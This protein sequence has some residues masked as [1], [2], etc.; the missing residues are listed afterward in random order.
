ML[1]PHCNRTINVKRSHYHGI[2][3]TGNTCSST[4]RTDPPNGWQLETAR[5]LLFQALNLLNAKRFFSKLF[6][7]LSFCFLFLVLTCRF[8]KNRAWPKSFLQI[9][10]F[11]MRL[12]RLS[13][14]SCSCSSTFKHQN[15]HVA[16]LMKTSSPAGIASGFSCWRCPLDNILRKTSSDFLFALDQSLLPLL[17]VHFGYL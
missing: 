16:T 13:P 7:I 3:T 4:T 11:R 1:N 6:R 12:Q 2:H 14:R 15:D 9:T 17:C 8:W 10:T 5:R